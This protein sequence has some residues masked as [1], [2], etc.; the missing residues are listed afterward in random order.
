MGHVGVVC[1][2]TAQGEMQARGSRIAQLGMGPRAPT[3]E[4]LVFLSPASATDVG[5]GS[6]GRKM[7]KREK[8]KKNFCL[9]HQTHSQLTSFHTLKIE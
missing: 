8:E 6:N 1:M 4:L 2:P 7:R 9:E 5:S 3:D